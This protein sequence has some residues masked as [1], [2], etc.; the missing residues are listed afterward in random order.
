MTAAYHAKRYA[1]YAELA[2][3]ALDAHEPF[4]TTAYRAAL[5]ALGQAWT[6]G[7]AAS[8]GGSFPAQPVGDLLAIAQAMFNKYAASAAAYAA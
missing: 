1:I 5:T 8:G 3:A 7:T 4:N 6:T 2:K